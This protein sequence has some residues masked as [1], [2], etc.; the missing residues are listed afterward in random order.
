MK[1]LV[2]SGGG[3]PGA[4]EAG[5]IC[6][7]ARAG[8]RFELVCGTSIGALNGALYAQ[9]DLAA[10]ERVWHTIVA[11][12][13][14]VPVPPVARLVDLAAEISRLGGDPVLQKVVDVA[15]AAGDALAS[16]PLGPILALTGA[17]DPGPL[18]A[19]LRDELHAE[20]LVRSL[21]VA[22]T[23]VTH[24]T[25]DAFYHFAGPDVAARAAE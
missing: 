9:D 12:R 19:L 13:P 10:L 20:R 25:C 24:T 5:V 1:A 14:L 2:L 6:G 21:V 4:Y 22:A 7:L 8:E 17:L 18:V 3:A 15:R 16:F 23:N 11:R